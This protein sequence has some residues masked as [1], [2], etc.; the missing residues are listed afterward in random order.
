[1]HI[2]KAGSNLTWAVTE[3]KKEMGGWKGRNLGTLKK[4]ATQI[5]EYSLKADFVTKIPLIL[6][7]RIWL[8][9]PI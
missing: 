6:N 8:I 7:A 3:R 5:S 4:T 9:I 2:K 1:M